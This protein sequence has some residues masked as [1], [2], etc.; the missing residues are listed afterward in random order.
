MTVG[1]EAVRRT[2]LVL[3][4][5]NA[6]CAPGIEGPEQDESRVADALDLFS[7]GEPATD[8]ALGSGADWGEDAVE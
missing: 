6:G 3:S 5:G 2:L 4:D 1:F 8:L 7:L